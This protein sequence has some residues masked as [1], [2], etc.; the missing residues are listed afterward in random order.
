M[1]I[2]NKKMSF[3][4]ELFDKTYLFKFAD[5]NLSKKSLV[6]VLKLF[7]INKKIFQQ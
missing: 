7:N 6:F 1:A 3:L 4:N 2:L 5:S